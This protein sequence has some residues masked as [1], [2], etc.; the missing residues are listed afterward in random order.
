MSQDNATSKVNM[1][2]TSKLQGH[3]KIDIRNHKPQC[4]L[5]I[6]SNMQPGMAAESHG[7]K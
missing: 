2:F 6:P 7:Q 5:G 3:S 4:F 1:S